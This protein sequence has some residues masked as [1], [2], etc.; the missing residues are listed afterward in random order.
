MTDSPGRGSDRAALWSL[1]AANFV[2]GT[3]VLLPVGLL[4]QL[5]RELGVSIPT[6]GLLLTVGGAVIAIGAPL[7]AAV[8]SRIDRQALLVAGLGLY[9]AGHAISALAPGFMVLLV[10]RALMIIAAGIVTPQAAATIGAMVP[11]DRRSAAISFVFL[12]WS[13]A[14]V[15]GMPA[16]S[17]IGDHWGWRAAYAVAAI[18]SALV[19]AAILVTI[20]KGIR[21]AP[22][23]LASWRQAL[24]DPALV[25]VLLV[26]A[27]NSASQFILFGYLKPYFAF[28]L[29]AT[30]GTIALLLA[31]QGVWG[32]VGNFAASRVVGRLGEAPTV[33]VGLLS[34]TIGLA[35]IGVAGATLPALLLGI[36]LWGSGSFSANSIQQARLVGLIPAFASA[37]IALNTSCTYLGQALGSAIGG[38]LIATGKLALLPWGAA[39]GMA[40]AVIVSVL[41]ARIV[42]RR[43]VS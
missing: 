2:I 11:P 29:A 17:L 1:L 25:L 34:M 16:A 36:L 10:T 37:S 30:P 24:G 21:V 18:L 40:L 14:M 42:I 23:S 26:T 27:L 33:L 7:A 9:A 3:G 38:G 39:A 4:D 15:A 20:P 35:L 8:T 31:W 43:Q 32:V 12:G 41:A 6:A 28:A 5:S 13:M 19:L 22:L